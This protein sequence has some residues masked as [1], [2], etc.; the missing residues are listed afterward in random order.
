MDPITA[1]MMRSA[2][3]SSAHHSY[4]YQQPSTPR[5]QQAQT[6]YAPPPGAQQLNPQGNIPNKRRKK[7]EPTPAELER[8]WVLAA[9]MT[10]ADQGKK[11][12]RS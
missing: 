8:E 6:A 3:S 10:E 11:R 1:S 2:A 5:P 9:V 4:Q 12:K 7:R